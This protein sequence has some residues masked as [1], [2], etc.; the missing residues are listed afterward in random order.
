MATCPTTLPASWYT[1]KAIYSLERRAVF[2]KSWMLLGAVTRFPNEGE[3]YPYEMAQID[4]TVRRTSSDWKSIKV[5]SDITSDTV[6]KGSKMRSHL[7]TTGLLFVAL[8][9]EAPSFDEFFPGLEDLIAHVD[10][11]QFSPRRSLNYNGNY[12]W[13]A[14]VDGYQ[15]CLHCAYAHPAFSKIYTPHSYKVLNKQNYSQ[16]L[17]ET[18]KPAD[19]L[20]LYFFPN[21]TLNLYGGGMSSFR[22]GPS[23]DPTKTTMEF[24]YYHQSPAG[25]EEFEKYY[26]FARNVAVED[27]ELCE[28]AQQNLNVGIYTEGI[29]NPNKENGV[30]YYQGRVLE[31]CT[32]L[33]EK[34]EKE[35]AALPTAVLGPIS[36]NA[37]EPC[38]A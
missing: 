17:A 18:N 1:S 28:K 37:A 12:N 14:M 8:S 9:D 38:P 13:K 29:L 22:V 11:T 6:H 30:A 36:V 7:T 26:R 25:S 10:F 21:S 24:D 32:A 2:L 34:E 4:F 20:F 19:G 3:N 16:H 33:Y 27:H 31:M 23:S 5:F 35:Q 15:E